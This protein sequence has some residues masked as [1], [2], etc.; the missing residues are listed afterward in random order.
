[1]FPNAYLYRFSPAV[2]NKA[3]PMPMTLTVWLDAAPS[4]VSLKIHHNTPNETIVPMTAADPSGKVFHCTLQPNMIPAGPN[5]AQR[6]YIGQIVPM[7]GDNSTEL[8]TTIDVLT[9][10]VLQISTQPVAAD[11]QFSEHL[12][13]IIVPAFPDDFGKLPIGEQQTQIFKL[14]NSFYAHF[15]DDYDFLHIV[16]AGSYAAN[17]GHIAVRNDAK[18]IGKNLFDNTPLFGSKGRLLGITMFPISWLFDGADRAV[19]HELGHQWINAMDFPP[20]GQSIPHWPLSDLATD[21]LGYSK[22]NEEGLQFDFDLQPV[23]GG[24]Y[25]L[26]ASD[27]P[28]VYSDLSLYLMGL[29]PANQVKPHFVFANQNQTPVDN[30]TLLGPVTTVTINDVIAGAGQVRSPDASQSQK[31]FRVAT[32]LVTKTGFADPDQMRLYDYFAARAGA[33][34]VQTNANGAG[35]TNPFYLATKGHGRLDP[36][37]KRNILVDSSRDGGV[38][39][40]PQQSG[41]NANAPHQGKA[42]ADHLRSLGHKVMELP[43][44]TTITPALLSDF[45]IVIRVAGVGSYTAAELNAYDAW[46]KDF[47]SLLLLVE[48]HPQDALASHFGLQFKSIVRGKQNLSNFTPHPVTVGVGPLFYPGGSGL[49]AHPPTATVLGKLSADSFLDLNDNQ[50]QDAGE[51][52][53]PAALGVMPFGDG[54]IVFCGDANLWE[55][56]PQP[57]VKNTLHWFAAP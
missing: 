7:P 41:F 18:G 47:G 56:V 23:A 51:P 57:L 6:V 15:D 52:S 31:R 20:F 42:L 40:Y 24:K 28:R 27:Q 8:V 11:V 49:T 10:S 5:N 45:D 26:T 38:W 30:G 46:V 22:K 16:L 44:P 35:L 9:A 2:L 12:F 53:A 48:H 25:Q 13:N 33:K 32:I 4:S 21:L 50:K 55:Q 34:T 19:M 43:R 14:S 3:A 36:R 29:L 39:W 37:I 1:M 17:R 54:R